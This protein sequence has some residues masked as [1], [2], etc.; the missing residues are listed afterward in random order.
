MMPTESKERYLGPLSRPR[1]SS[2]SRLPPLPCLPDRVVFLFPATGTGQ[3]GP[4][5]PAPGPGDATHLRLAPSCVC[6]PRPPSLSRAPGHG[7]RRVVRTQPRRRRGQ[8][9]AGGT[10][11]GT[12]R[13]SDLAAPVIRGRGGAGA[14]RMRVQDGGRPVSRSGVVAGTAPRHHLWILDRLQVELV[15]VMTVG[16]D[17]SSTTATHPLLVYAVAR[18]DCRV[19]QPKLVLS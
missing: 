17:N 13:A 8:R 12:P 18:V 10:G 3:Q 6:L 5:P 16:L 11:T 4:R 7:R 14:P 19:E 2:R 1:D 15:S 9:G